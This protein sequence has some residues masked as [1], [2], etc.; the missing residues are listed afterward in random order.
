MES[1]GDCSGTRQK[2][3]LGKV[4]SCSS[5]WGEQLPGIAREKA[6]IYRVQPFALLLL[7]AARALCNPAFL[8]QQLTPFPAPH[9]S[10]LPSLVT[11]G[12]EALIVLIPAGRCVDSKNNKSPSDSKTFGPCFLSL[13]LPDL[14]GS[15]WILT[16]TLETPSSPK[17][18]AR[19]NAFT[20]MYS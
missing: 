7:P 5:I 3:A 18:L 9:R 14:S 19:L 20:Q 6:V 12:Q 1:S 17:N 4:L 2:L 10:C 13:M 15:S 11:E 16:A 8:L